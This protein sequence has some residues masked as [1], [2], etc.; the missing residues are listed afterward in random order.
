[1]LTFDYDPSQE[2][3]TIPAYISSIHADQGNSQGNVFNSLMHMSAAVYAQISDQFSAQRRSL[4]ERKLK[5]YASAT[6]IHFQNN[7]HWIPFPTGSL[8]Y[9]TLE[10]RRILFNN[11]VHPIFAVLS[12][13]SW[14]KSTHREVIVLLAFLSGSS[15]A[16]ECPKNDG[17][18]PLFSFKNVHRSLAI[19][20]FWRT[21]RI[22]VQVDV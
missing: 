9:S 10:R 6:D 2:L 18:T 1:M 16:L 20:Y 8:A 3:P 22:H 12:N 4:F 21:Q 17:N 15:T 19:I 14:C 11:P 13:I 5:K 7:V